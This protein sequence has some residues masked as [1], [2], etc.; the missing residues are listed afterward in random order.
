MAIAHKFHE[1][2]LKNLRNQK[3]LSN[4]NKS[5]IRWNGHVG[6]PMAVKR[7]KEPLNSQE[8]IF[9][10]LSKNDG[11]DDK[12]EDGFTSSSDDCISLSALLEE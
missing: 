11:D 2:V 3:N 6:R 1:M 4:G 7:L 5:S 10:D 12:E 8:D 9:L